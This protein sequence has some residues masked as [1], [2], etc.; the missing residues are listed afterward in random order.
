MEIGESMC[1]DGL[2]KMI[3]PSLIE[4]THVQIFFSL[5]IVYLCGGQ[6]GVWWCRNQ[7]IN[8]EYFKRI[9]LEY[10]KRTQNK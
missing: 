4:Q 3:C 5:I 9:L 8:Q 1:M 2:V 7:G 6:S 10:F